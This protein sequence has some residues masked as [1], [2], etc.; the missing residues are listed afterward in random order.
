MHF[1]YVDFAR[2]CLGVVELVALRRV[3]PRPAAQ[4]L[5]A[6]RADRANRSAAARGGVVATRQPLPLNRYFCPQ[7][8][9][10]S[11]SICGFPAA[12]LASWPRGKDACS[13]EFLSSLSIR[14]V[15]V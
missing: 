15:A 8:L 1:G 2:I 5:P 10:L 3:A 7:N 6:N 14:G 9:C 13:W 11:T 4:R 12:S